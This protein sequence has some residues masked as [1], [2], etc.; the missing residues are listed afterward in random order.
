MNTLEKIQEILQVKIPA[1]DV[2]KVVLNPANL[3]LA[4]VVKT[5][6]LSR[7]SLPCTSG[8]KLLKGCMFKIMTPSIADIDV[9][10]KNHEL[11]SCTIPDDLMYTVTGIQEALMIV[12]DYI[13]SRTI[14]PDR[15]LPSD[16]S[17]FDEV[18]DFCRSYIRELTNSKNQHIRSQ[19]VEMVVGKDKP[20]PPSYDY[21]PIIFEIA[22]ELIQNNVASGFRIIFAARLETSDKPEVIYFRSFL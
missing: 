17:V 22:L 13:R 1:M 14:R 3:N 10:L 5:K 9:K 20:I 21:T 4:A 18:F 8:V 16:D 12:H 2:A 15:I 6:P 11:V 7:Y 19:F